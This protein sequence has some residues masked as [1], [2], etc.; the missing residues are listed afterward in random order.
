LYEIQHISPNFDAKVKEKTM[1][2][3]SV[4]WGMLALA[5]TVSFAVVGCGDPLQEGGKVTTETAQVSG[6]GNVKAVLS[7]NASGPKKVIITWDA[8]DDVASYRVYAKQKGKAP[9]Q[10]VTASYSDWTASYKADG[11][12]TAE[13][14]TDPD[15]WSYL[16]SSL[17]AF[18]T[19]KEYEFGVQ[20]VN[21]LP[22]KTNSGIEWA[23]AIALK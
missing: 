11:D 7:N 22:N 12:V 2:K 5:L 13:D 19:D 4:F 6:P 14:N 20:S 17:S 1:A 8:A 9:L 3:K 16:V 10:S 23:A 15:K 18:D 21:S